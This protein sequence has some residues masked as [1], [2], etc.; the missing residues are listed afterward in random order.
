[1]TTGIAALRASPLADYWP[2]GDGSAEWQGGAVPD[3]VGAGAPPPGGLNV[4]DLSAAA[5]FR[6]HGAYPEL[7]LID[8]GRVAEPV[9]GWLVGRLPDNDLIA[10]PSPFAAAP[11]PG[12]VA[13][14]QRCDPGFAHGCWIYAFG[15]ATAR[16]FAQGCEID[17]R[18]GTFGNR[19]LRQ[20]T[21]F[22]IAALVVRDD[23]GAM[24]GYHILACCSYAHHLAGMIGHLQQ[25]AGGQVTGLADLRRVAGR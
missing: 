1:M 21:L 16:L 11:V 18:V 20:T 6:F 7:G 5:R 4:V 10:L 3:R 22:R 23:A 24:P 25:R 12:F 14:A 9:P 17:M 2:A 19:Q 13:G 8:R 15:Q